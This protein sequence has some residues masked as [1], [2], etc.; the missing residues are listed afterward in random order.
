VSGVLQDVRVL[1]AVA[2]AVLELL[3][4]LFGDLAAALRERHDRLEVGDRRRDVIRAGDGRGVGHGDSSM[5][6]RPGTFADAHT[7]KAAGLLRRC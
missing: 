7:W 3:L 4:G 6:I 1:G 5:A 2:I